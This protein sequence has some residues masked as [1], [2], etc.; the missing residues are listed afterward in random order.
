[1]CFATPSRLAHRVGDR[2][3]AGGTDAEAYA[4]AVA[5]YLGLARQSTG[6]LSATRLCHVATDRRRSARDTCSLDRRSRWPGTSPRR[7]PFA[8][9]P[10]GW[11][12][13]DG[14][15]VAKALECLPRRR[16]ARPC[17][18]ADAGA[19]GRRERL[20]ISTDPPYYDNIGYSDLSDFFYVWLRRSLRE[21]PP[22]PPQHDARPE[23]R[24]ARRQPVPPRR[25][26]R[27]EGVLRGR[28]PAR[29]RAR[30]RDRARRTSRSP[31]T[32]R[33]SS[34]T[35]TTTGRRRP[36]GRRCSTG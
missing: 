2:L 6:G 21:R 15:I 25:Q 18:Q 5:T 32:T 19:A 7:I 28:L 36:A 14:E 22:R 31:S 10:A 20:L 30:P 17:S 9:R 23:G 4:D 33:S 11:S 16:P 27:R 26:G 24:G 34:P 3:E 13:R 12:A 35:P 8:A 29:V 1:M